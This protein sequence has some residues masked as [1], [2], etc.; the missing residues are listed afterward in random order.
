MADISAVSMV[1]FIMFSGGHVSNHQ[2]R[3]ISGLDLPPTQ[4]AIVENESVCSYIRI[5]EHEDVILVVTVGEL[6]RPFIGVIKISADLQV[7][8][9]NEETAEE[10]RTDHHQEHWS[11]SHRCHQSSREPPKWDLHQRRRQDVATSYADEQKCPWLPLDLEHLKQH[12]G[13]R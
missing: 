1:L 6:K 10:V 12:R 4:D 11:G 5:P 13:L 9:R 8:S 7:L 3:Q 2:D